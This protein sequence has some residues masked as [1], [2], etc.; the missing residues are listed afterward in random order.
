MK[1]VCLYLLFLLLCTSP[2]YG[3][4][5][6]KL[7][8]SPD[9]ELKYNAALNYYEKGDYTKT[10][11]LLEDI[12]R[13]YKGTETAENILYVLSTSYFNKKDYISA[14]HYYNTYVNTYLRGSHYTECLF[15]LAYCY[16]KQSP[17]PELDQTETL[18]AI[19]RFQIY[20]NQF[21]NDLRIPEAKKMLDEMYNKLA[22]REFYNARLYYNLGNYKGNNYRA[23]IVTA[24]NAMNDYPDSPYKEEFALI[25]V[26]SKYK[27]AVNSVQKKVKDRSEDAWDECYYFLQEYPESKH[28]KEV[29]KI[30]SSL[31]KIIKPTEV[32]TSLK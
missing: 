22:D 30:A 1:K 12:S 9:T 5:Y 11:T 10:I 6:S 19:E 4:A 13:T 7:L 27:E 2:V 32:E 14:S 16:Y 31:N 8:K 20:I 23:A 24:H 17:H 15:M 25:I 21:P 26:R 28:K 29:E 18:K 3:S